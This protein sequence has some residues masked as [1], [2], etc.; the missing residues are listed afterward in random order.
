MTIAPVSTALWVQ[1]T[2][3]KPP[4]CEIVKEI[5]LKILKESAI[6]LGLGT[7]VC[8]FVPTPMGLSMMVGA[9][10]VQLL[11]STLFHALG[12]FASYHNYET[13]ATACSWITGVNFGYLTGRNSQTILH[14]AGHALASLLVYK[15]P[16]P[17]IEVFPFRGGHTSYYK[18]GLTSFGH[19]LGAAA[20]NC[21]TIASG[22]A[23]TLLV[24]SAL[25]AVGIAI[26]EEYPE[27]G[28]Y[29]IAWASI[30]F[31]HHAEYAY[32]ALRVEKWNL[33][34]DFAHLSI[35]GLHPVDASIVILAIPIVITLGMYLWKNKK[36][37]THG[38][39]AS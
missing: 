22:P 7:I 32:S 38:L 31:L 11:V 23:L 26:L 19:K 20:A 34:N 27:F 25:L 3:E 10:I 39:T 6:T 8:L 12:A 1:Q 9:T 13:V 33:S 15:N 30:D 28:K 17:V 37:P 14:E 2:P 4:I 35:F 21:L 18:T 24:S 16:R 29:L 5:V 36:P